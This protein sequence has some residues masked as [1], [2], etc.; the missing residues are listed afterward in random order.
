MTD[1]LR[2][3]H[4]AAVAHASAS[5][6]FASLTAQLSLAALQAQ[7]PELSAV[8]QP[9]LI[10]R[11][12]DEASPAHAVAAVA[13]GEFLERLQVA[14]AAVVKSRRRPSQNN[15]RVSKSDLRRARLDI[16]AASPGS[17]IVEMRP[18]TD[19]APA[20]DEG[21]SLPGGTTTW[22]ELALN[23]L[24]RALPDADDDLGDVDSVVAAPPAIR[25]AIAALVQPG[26]VPAVNA[27]M[28]LL[29]PGK[30]QIAAHL[31]ESHAQRLREIL[32]IETE[33]RTIER[34]IGRLDG[35]RTSRRI[36]Y[37]ES[38]DGIELHGLMDEQLI[39]VVREHLNRTVEAV[40]EVVRTQSRGGKSRPPQYRLIDVNHQPTL[41]PVDEP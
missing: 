18:H 21:S 32:D 24:L 37:F 30:E 1:D 26:R 8:E 41:P 4:D 27:T 29:R 5:D 22:T 33:T 40:L 17:L 28:A 38:V 7:V 39:D 35:L 15:S 6:H 34:K 10:I 25:R 16:L 9:T 13:A 20:D 23:D 36:F 12:A 19:D 14:V 2:A 3:L 31:T 11:L